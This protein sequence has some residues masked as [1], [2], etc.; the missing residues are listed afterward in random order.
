MCA[1][2]S[3]PRQPGST[4]IWMVS[5]F[6][7]VGW[8]VI[9]LHPC[10]RY[11]SWIVSDRAQERGAWAPLVTCVDVLGDSLVVV[12]TVRLMQQP[13]LFA[14]LLGDALVVM[15]TVRLM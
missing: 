4:R 1:L 14:L 8:V 2:P 6:S 15:G 11:P 7:V 10:I 9:L 3:G 12:G 5:F 13:H